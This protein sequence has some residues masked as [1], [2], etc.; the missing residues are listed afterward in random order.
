MPTSAHTAG[1]IVLALLLGAAVTPPPTVDA[2][3]SAPRARRERRSP[4]L[5]AQAAAAPAVA[6]I[7]AD[8]RLEL[9]EMSELEKEFARQVREYRD[10][11]TE[12]IKRVYDD[13]KARHSADYEKA[14][15]RYEASERDERREAIAVFERFVVRY[16]SDPKFTPDA[17]TRLAELYYEKAVDDQLVAEFEYQERVKLGA[18]DEA[19]PEMQRSFAKSIDLYRRII[20]NFPDYRLNDSIHYLLGW[21]LSEQGELEP[22]RD[23]FRVLIE[24]FPTSRYVPEAWMRIGEYYFDYTGPD[25]NEKLVEGIRAYSEAI[26]FKDSPLYDKALYKLGWSYYRLDDFDNGVNAFVSLLD[27]YESKKGADKDSSG[28]LR[29]E[30]IQ[31]TAISFADEKW[32]SVQKLEEYFARLGGRPYE[33]EMYRRVG[34]VLFDSTRY[35]DSVSAYRLV[36]ARKP[37]A[38]DAPQ[39][40]DKIVQAFARDQNKPAAFAE[41][42]KIVNDYNEK[43]AWAEAN[44][45]DQEILKAARDLVERSLLATAQYHHAQAAEYEKIAADEAT[46]AEERAQKGLQALNEYR[47]AAKAY[48]RYLAEFPHSKNL[49]EIQYYHAETLY[50]SG[51]FGAAADEYARVRDSNTDN[52]YLANAAYYVVLALQREIEL[53]IQQ[54]VLEDRQPCNPESCKAITQ[55]DPQPIP[56]I[57]L[58]LIQA[59]DIYLSKIPTAE[60]APILSYK[61]G[62]TYFTY[63]HFEEARKRYEDVIARFPDKTVADYAYD[64]ILISYLLMQDWMNVEI[65]ADKQLKGSKAVQ[66]DPEKFQKVRLLKY[67][68]RFNRANKLFEQKKWDEAAKLYMSIVDDTERE[69]VQNPGWGK[70]ENSDKALFNAASC[71]YEARRFESAMRTNERLVNDYPDSPLAQD[72][73]FY[74]ASN[75]DKAFEFDKAIRMYTKLVNE[76]PNSTK[77]SAALFNAGQLLEAVQEYERA[78]QA[79]LDYAELFPD[80][81]DAAAQAYQAAVVY[82][83]AKKYDLVIKGLQ[84]FIRD[85][86]NKKVTDKVTG[87]V[88]TENERVVNAYLKIGHAH[89]EMKN[90]TAALKSFREAVEEFEKRKLGPDQYL[91]AQSAAEARFWQIEAEFAVFQKLKFDPKGRG[92]RLQKDTEAQLKNLATKLEEIK[93]KYREIFKYGPAAAEWI[94]AALFRIG[95]SDE[96]FAQK[97]LDSP[98]PAE[99]KN[100]LGEDGCIE[101]KIAFEEKVNPIL[102]RA[103]EAYEFAQTKSEELRIVNKWTKLINEKVCL[104]SP[105]MCKSLKDPLIKFIDEDRSPRPLVKGDGKTQ[106][107]VPWERAGAVPDAPPA[108]P[109]PAAPVESAPG[110]GAPPVGPAPTEA[111]PVP[112]PAAPVPAAAPGGGAP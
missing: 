40:Q 51:Q 31:Y 88:R 37:F 73:L 54:Q 93:A 17:M 82:Q 49:Y 61:A 38:P 79:Y 59:A 27:Y 81:P 13:R 85:Y 94:L 14:L 75:A 105:N 4:A 22:S 92:A 71:F 7:P 84:K 16:P 66:K 107:I 18:V 103:V 25:I 2:E 67:G 62:Q 65:Y 80:E 58:R 34:D 57:R 35:T 78:A 33:D 36:L 24:K 72:A 91:A 42:E 55:F 3:P 28:D 83:R 99:V 102:A 68:A 6:S 47:E 96:Q 21:C 108:A 15:R 112:T 101:Y 87:D 39:V 86:G 56:D 111:G 70:W 89:R 11:A 77:R 45:G 10:D 48:G 106:V 1:A 110:I 44:K 60:D 12:L 32:G 23:T 53:L 19:P 64:D 97:L 5:V 52:K 46:P 30:A 104:N 98:C 20:T 74:V 109:P 50:N 9:D 90:E 95:E 69:A 100:E 43:S 26:K 41:R 29:A 63:F 8:A 76:Y